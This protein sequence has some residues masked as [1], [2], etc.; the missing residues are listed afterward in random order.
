[1]ASELG[2]KADT[3]LSDLIALDFFKRSKIQREL[4][5]KIFN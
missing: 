5:Y 2:K 1:M 3:C 4:L